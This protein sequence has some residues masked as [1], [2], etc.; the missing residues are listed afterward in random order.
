MTPRSESSR[1]LRLTPASPRWG[2]LLTAA[3][4]IPLQRISEAGRT[5]TPKVSWMRS[6]RLYRDS[7]CVSRRQAREKRYHENPKISVFPVT[8]APRP[9]DALWQ[10]ERIA[11]QLVWIGTVVALGSED[12]LSLSRPHL[13]PYTRK[14]LK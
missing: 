1:R 2:F 9:S 8:P 13:V 5:G 6:S 3:S 7:G 11:R 10:E 4:A 12:G 14:L